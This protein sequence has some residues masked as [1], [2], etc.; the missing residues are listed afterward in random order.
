MRFM[1]G[2]GQRPI[3]FIHWHGLMLIVQTSAR[4]PPSSATNCCNDAR[5]WYWSYN[6][7]LR[8][9]D[10]GPHQ[11]VLAPTPVFTMSC[12]ILLYRLFNYSLLTVNFINC[13]LSIAAHHSQWTYCMSPSVHGININNGA[14]SEEQRLSWSWV[15]C[16][17]WRRWTV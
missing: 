16:L 9:L 2:P 6:H 8:V 4:A 15:L 11:P 14:R 7:L 10:Q 13:Q 1:M 17:E 12:Q 5:L 3:Q